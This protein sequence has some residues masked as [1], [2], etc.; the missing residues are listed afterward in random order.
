M[1][2]GN[3]ILLVFLA[4]ITSCNE[5]T[6]SFKLSRPSKS[7][8][9][10]DSTLIINQFDKNCL[11]V[12]KRYFL[13]N[14]RW[15]VRAKHKKINNGYIS[16]EQIYAIRK[17]ERKGYYETTM[18]G[19]YSYFFENSDIFQT[20]VIVSFENI[21]G[22]GNDTN[23]ITYASYPENKDI[24]TIIQSEDSLPVLGNTSTSYLI[25]QEN[26]INIEIFEQS[27]NLERKFTIQ[28]IQ[29]LNAELSM[30]LDNLDEIEKTGISPIKKFY[31]IQ[32]DSNYF[33]IHDGVQSGVYGIRAGLST[34]KKGVVY[35]KI[36]NSDTNEPLFADRIKLETTNEIGWSEDGKL[37]LP[38]ESVLV[39]REG[40]PSHKYKARFEIW[41]R[42]NK[43]DEI[44][45]TEKER[46]I[47]GWG[48]YRR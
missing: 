19:Y 40:D 18:N 10:L 2:I 27:K 25:L 48:G 32:L 34:N 6:H 43:G 22:Y 1:K 38:Y 24:K 11:D 31:P 46:I 37:I 20:R 4:F 44:K 39:I 26:S 29:E 21:Y 16:Y 7:V 30:V 13:G 3:L 5:L 12:L 33:K 17:E 8:I 42:P 41:F 15:D 35:I 9:K 28:T 45:L 23:R 47:S 14:P 36:F